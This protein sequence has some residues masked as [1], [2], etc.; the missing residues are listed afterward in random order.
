[1]EF[2]YYILDCLMNAESAL[3]FESNLND[4]FKHYAEDDFSFTALVYGYQNFEAMKE[5][6]NDRYKIVKDMYEY[7][8]DNEL[9]TKDRQ[10]VRKKIWKDSYKQDYTKY[11][12]S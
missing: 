11:I 9:E 6:F 4:L 3:Q 7:I 10:D 12:N 5:S 1:M 2:E 8:N